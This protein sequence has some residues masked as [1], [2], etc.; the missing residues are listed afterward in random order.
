MEQ[1]SENFAERKAEIRERVKLFI[2][3]SDY[4]VN[5]IM[6]GLSDQ[7]LLANEITYVND[8]WEKVGTV[9]RHARK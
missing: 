3:G 5:Q 7:L 9:H 2:A 8:I 4:E 6:A 1:F